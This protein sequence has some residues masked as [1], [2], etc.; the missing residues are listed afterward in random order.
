MN[1]LTSPKNI[2][3]GPVNDVRPLQENADLPI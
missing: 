2:R 3:S 1:K